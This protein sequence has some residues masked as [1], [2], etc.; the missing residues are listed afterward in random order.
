M[1]SGPH[2]PI[3]LF[4]KVL[5]PAVGL[6]NAVTHNPYIRKPVSSF[7]LTIT[8]L[9]GAKKIRSKC[10]YILDYVDLSSFGQYFSLRRTPCLQSPESAPAR[11]VSESYEN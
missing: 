4:L 6:Q 10:T 7:S 11:D 5:F 9:T 3:F 1:R 8:I 2:G